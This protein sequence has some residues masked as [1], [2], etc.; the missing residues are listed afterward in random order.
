MEEEEEDKR[1]REG[2]RRKR[3]EE[4]EMVEEE[5]GKQER[6]GESGEGSSDLKRRL[7]AR[8][9]ARARRGKARAPRFTSRQRASKRCCLG[10]RPSLGA[11]RFGLAPGLNQATEP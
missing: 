5:E 10:A 9:G 3:K 6:R 1:I 8:L 11:G 7:G 4:D 2:E